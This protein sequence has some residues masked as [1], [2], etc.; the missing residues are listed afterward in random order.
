M[1]MRLPCHVQL[2]IG[3]ISMI[4]KTMIPNIL[5]SVRILLIPFFIYFLL[6]DLM[7]GKLIATIIFFIASITDALDGKLARKY[8]VVTR[9]GIFFDPMADK[10]L[11]LSALISFFI[12][13]DI[14]LWMVIVISF[15]DIIITLLRLF[16][17]S[18]GVTLITSKFGKLKTITQISAIIIILIYLTIESYQII[19]I[20]K[21]FNDFPIIHLIMLLTT[22]I[23]SI[24]GIQYFYQNHKTIRILLHKE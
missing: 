17:E 7:H 18:K 20:I 22:I 1:L 14:R 8:D 11:V 6:A 21:L 19:S 15:R 9:F 24:T 16:M 12:L 23:T 5:T 2:M 3:F 10:M 4:N 13:G